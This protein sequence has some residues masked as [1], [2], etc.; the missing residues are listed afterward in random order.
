LLQ[1]RAGLGMVA[2]GGR[3]YAIGGGWSNYLGFS[4]RFDP[5]D[6]NWIPLESPLVG[7]WRNLGLA[8]SETSIYAVGGWN[9]DYLNRTYRL[10]LLPFRIFISVPVP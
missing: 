3:I 7:E 1:A 8:A 10:D 6:Q 4:E 5:V 9:G 2:V